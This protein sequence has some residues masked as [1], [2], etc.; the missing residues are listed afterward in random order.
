MV[1]IVS[2]AVDQQRVPLR[3]VGVCGLAA[4]LVSMVE[5]VEVWWLASALRFVPRHLD[6]GGRC[7]LY[8]CPGV[9]FITG[10]VW[11]PMYVV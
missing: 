7:G 4:S 8:V 1:G 10:V 6:Y 9:V 5:G 11:D 2:S 3:Q